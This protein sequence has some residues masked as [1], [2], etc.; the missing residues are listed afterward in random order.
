VR[1]AFELANVINAHWLELV[2]SGQFNTWQVRTLDAIR[3]CRT[4]SLGGH[5]DLCTSCGHVR[6]S[7]NSCRNR[8]CPKCQQ[9]QRERWIQAREAELLPATYFHL[10]FTLPEAL[11]RLCLF[12]PAKIYTLLFDT[13]WS[14]MKSFARDQKHLGAD[15]GMISIL[16][17]WGQNLSLHPHIHCIVPGG[18]VTTSGKWKPARSNGKFL[19]PV[20]AMSTVFRARFVAVLRSQFKGLEPSFFNALFNTPWVVYAKRPFEGPKHVIEYLGRYTHKVAISNHRILDIQND[21]VTFRY[22]DYRDESKVK[23]M[24][25]HP[26]EFIRRFS[27]HILPKGFMRIRH[28][29]ILSS[30]GKLHVLP[31]LHQQLESRYEFPQEKHWKQISIERLGY[32]PDACPVCKKLSMITV[33]TFD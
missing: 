17:T 16:H 14:V 12:E 23:C 31:L 27:L 29:G 3:R 25:M 24:P 6:I 30:S 9:I 28:Y 19:F 21:Q 5:V 18:G 2:R 7:Y 26:M 13:A 11:N 10:V 20:K 22:K 15:S 33:L 32:N 1:P 4:A 8:H